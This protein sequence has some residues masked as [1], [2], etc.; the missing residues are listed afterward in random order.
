MRRFFILLKN[1]MKLSIRDMNMIIFAL[2]MPLA[3]LVIL[4]IIYGAKPAYDG[5]PYTFIEQSFGV[6]PAPSPCAPAA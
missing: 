5:A 4:G 6:R 3:I 1:E 2:L